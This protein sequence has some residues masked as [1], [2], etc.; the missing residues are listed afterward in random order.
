MKTLKMLSNKKKM[1]IGYRLLKNSDLAID[2]WLPPPT[3]HKCI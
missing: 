3:S 1:I 2:N